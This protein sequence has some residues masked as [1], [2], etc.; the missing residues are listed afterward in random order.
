[1]SC[2]QQHRY[3]TDF[4]SFPYDQSQFNGR[5]KCAGCAYEQGHILV[6]SKAPSINISFEEISDS[7]AGTV[8]Y[9][10]VQA[11]FSSGYLDGVLASYK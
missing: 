1:M 10:S 11:V 4:E 7:Q 8:R 2:P 5:H 9:K 3:S 6:L